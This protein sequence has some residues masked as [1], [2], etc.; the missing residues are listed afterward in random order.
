[1]RGSCHNPVGVVTDS[2]IPGGLRGMSNLSPHARRDMEEVPPP[3][4]SE[5]IQVLV[6][7]SSRLT[8]EATA[9]H[10]GLPAPGPARAVR[11]GSGDGRRGGCRLVALPWGRR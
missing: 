11:D 1:M 7:V 3:E 10:G 9:R 2:G 8:I 4:A 6:I 5:T